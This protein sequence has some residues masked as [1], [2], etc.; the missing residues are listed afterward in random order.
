MELKS[1][2]RANAKELVELLIVPCGI[3]IPLRGQEHEVRALL[4]VP[5]GIEI[6]FP[7]LGLPLQE[8]FNRTMWN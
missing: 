7:A 4:I 2:R 3:E 5:C 8:A 6:G 1:H